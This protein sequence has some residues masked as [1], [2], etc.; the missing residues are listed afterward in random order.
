M[1]QI[2]LAD[3]EPLVLIGLQSLLDWEALGYSICG[4]ARNG[5][6]ALEMIEELR[7]DIV[8]ADIKMPRMDG[9]TL[10]RTCQERGALP[11]F[12]M[13]TSFE[14]FDFIKQ[15]MTA[16]AVDYL[17]KL[18]LSENTLKE[19]LARAADRVKKEQVLQKQLSVSSD[20]SQSMRSYRDH[21]F[22]RLYAGGFQEES[23]LR[24]PLQ[25]M[26]ITLKSDFYILA[27][28]ELVPNTELSSE[29][30]LKL[31]FSCVKMLE[32]IFRNYVSCYITGTDILRCNALFCLEEAQRADYPSL[33]RPLL[34]KAAQ[35]LY[36][37][38]TVRL[39]WAVG[40]PASSLLSL[41]RRRRENAHLEP[42]LC[43]AHPIQFVEG[44]DGDPTAGKM[45]VVAKV[46][47]YIRH[48][49]SEKLTLADV[50][51]VF[52]FSPNY[53][54]QLFGK[55]GDSGFVEFI[56]E[57]RIAAA[58]EML[59]QGDLK[60]YEI[61]RKLGFDS[62][63]YFSKVFKKVTGLSPREYQQKI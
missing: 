4:T 47:D 28:C 1:L 8:L 53:L 60:I 52:N 40:R 27:S 10:A 39:Y 5:Q 34:E 13:L 3:D 19:A 45:E 51:A 32:S 59:E 29:Q 48:H 23:E 36:R 17:V 11:V 12:I 62:S 63:F 21:F 50:A 25:H 30:Q 22:T 44:S 37:Y 16:G 61:A 15:A 14:E 35:I 49:L 54:S 2:L 56:T 46:Q 33:L 18:D 38:F 42:L 6:Q 24:K 41:S 55:Y 9:L 58:K 57:T 43:E 7:P 26:G 31:G 20:L